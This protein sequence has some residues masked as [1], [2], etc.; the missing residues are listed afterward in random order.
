MWLIILSVLVVGLV[1]A[2]VRYRRIQRRRSLFNNPFPEA[3]LPILEANVPLYLR[4]P[5]HLQ[6]ELQGLIQ[7]FLD[8][9]HFVGCA[10]LEI[11]AE[12]KVTIAAYACMLLLN[13]DHRYYPGF[14]TILVYPSAYVVQSTKRDGLV[15]S[16]GF[17][18]R[19]GES[20]H[21]GPI[22]LAWDSVLHGALD[23]KDGHNVV[24]HE[25]AHKL[26]EEDGSVDGV[27]LLGQR[28]RYISW[29][30]TM[31]KEFE[32]L[33]LRSDLGKASVLDHYGA[34]NPA[35]FFAVLTETFFEKPHQLKTRHPELYE[36][37]SAYYRLDP[38]EW[39]KSSDE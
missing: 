12:I 2:G 4:L 25:F 11:D 30:R 27:P 15:E 33:R 16:E 36:Q 20:W 13:R 28:S 17:E 3:W 9:K 35:E 1:W 10:G 34:T 8:E 21:R 23:I 7:V 31:S 24:F 29:A 26:D 5:L 14:I 39:V 22:V 6:R 32:A 18:V 19:L 37:V 38:V